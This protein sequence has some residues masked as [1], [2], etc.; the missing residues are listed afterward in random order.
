VSLWHSCWR[1]S[2]GL[3]KKM[4]RVRRFMMIFTAAALTVGAAGFFVTARASQRRAQSLICASSVVSICFAG[5]LWAQEHDGNFPTNFTCMS[6]ELATPQILSCSPTRRPRVSEWSSF[7]ANNCTYK[8]VTPGVHVAATNTVFLCC[9]I[10]GHL[11][12][13]DT[14]V[15]D[16]NR[17]RGKYE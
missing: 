6:H 15:F 13:P 1:G 14:T 11:G 3:T 16:G 12:Y 9:T 10:H 2:V 5:L 8:I 7:T 17:R 4:M